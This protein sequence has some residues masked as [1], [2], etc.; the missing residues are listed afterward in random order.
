[1]SGNKLSRI[2]KLDS[3]LLSSSSQTSTKNVQRQKTGED[4][5]HAPAKIF[6][7]KRK[8]EQAFFPATTTTAMATT[9]VG[10]ESA[11]ERWVYSSCPLVVDDEEEE[12]EGK[13]R[14]KTRYAFENEKSEK[15]RNFG[16]DNNNNN[17][18]ERHKMEALDVVRD[19]LERNKR[20][21]GRVEDVMRAK[22]PERK[23]LMLESTTSR[24]G[25]GGGSSAAA[26]NESNANR[27]REDKEGDLHR[28][29]ERRMRFANAE[30]E[31]YSRRGWK[32]MVRAKVGP[33]GDV[34][35]LVL[36]GKEATTG[37][38]TWESLKRVRKLWREYA[39]KELEERRKEKKAR[40]KT[41]TMDEH[42]DGISKRDGEEKDAWELFGAVVLVTKHRRA[43]LV[44]ESGVVVR[45]TKTNVHVLR[46][47]TAD[48]VSSLVVIPKTSGAE[49]TI[50]VSGPPISSASAA[51]KSK[52]AKLDE[53]EESRTIRV[54]F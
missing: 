43:N 23:T 36:G 3:R 12:T 41:T 18:R 1:M 32:K 27:F 14:G 42:V 4:G 9:T 13:S 21:I 47:T 39:A 50:S 30:R 15:R 48:D 46:K 16:R 54:S 8:L 53:G 52:E 17:E 38:L 29:E 6:T 22:L 5:E 10:E 33:R 51:A 24:K 2:A 20:D 19:L 28:K 37:A 7:K 40:K 45:E 44:G 25:A 34:G 35:G 11:S 49:L 31:E 26:G